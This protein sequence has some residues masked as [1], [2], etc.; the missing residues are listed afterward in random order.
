MLRGS[1]DGRSKAERSGT[2]SA[3]PAYAI[4]PVSLASDVIRPVAV[5]RVVLR[6]VA[7]R[8]RTIGGNTQQ[9]RISADGPGG[10]R[11]AWRVADIVGPR[12][13]PWPQPGGPVGR[14]R[15]RTP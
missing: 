5:G 9:S 8:P 3:R 1:L 2:D 15:L 4:L 12:R 6:R 11:P 10:S 14:C 13:A 7:P